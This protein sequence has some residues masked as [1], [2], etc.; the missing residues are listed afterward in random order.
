MLYEHSSGLTTIR[1]PGRD[2]TA[3]QQRFEAAK[4]YPRTLGKGSEKIRIS[5]ALFNSED[6]INQ[7]VQQVREFVGE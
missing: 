6:E 5:T 2:E 4:L 3:L 7:L 1:V